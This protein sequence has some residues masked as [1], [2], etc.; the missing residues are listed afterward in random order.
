MRETVNGECAPERPC[1]ARPSSVSVPGS[2]AALDDGQRLLRK[3]QVLPGHQQP[4]GEFHRGEPSLG[5]VGDHRQRHC[6]L[7]PAAEDSTGHRRLARSEVVTPESLSP[8]RRSSP[9][10]HVDHACAGQAV[11]AV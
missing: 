4:V 7:V 6:L 2:Q 1:W 9:G 8:T 5:D 3:L 11:A 10:M